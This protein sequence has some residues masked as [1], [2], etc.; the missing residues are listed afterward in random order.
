MGGIGYGTYWHCRYRKAEEEFQKIKE[1][2]KKV[3]AHTWT[4]EYRELAEAIHTAG[5]NA[6][7]IPDENDDLYNFYADSWQF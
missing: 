7:Y 3:P 2:T 4:S 6:F 1:I 5:Q